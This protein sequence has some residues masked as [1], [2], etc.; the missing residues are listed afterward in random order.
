MR[1]PGR[2]QTQFGRL[3][4][5]GM[6]AAMLAAG[7]DQT[8][9]RGGGGHGGG[10]HHGEG[11]IHRSGGHHG[12]EGA[13]DHGHRR[14]GRHGEVVTT[15]PHGVM[16]IDHR[17][18]RYFYHDGRFFDNH[19][20]GFIVINAPVGALVSRLPPESATV[21]VGG[22]RYFVADDNYYRRTDDGYLVVESPYHR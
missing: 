2:M 11:E 9:A 8:F 21:T 3:L 22:S 10:G 15:L 14:G 7:V 5:V 18:H 13:D 19:R 4:I 12:G 1:C 6:T 20:D 16:E 17:G